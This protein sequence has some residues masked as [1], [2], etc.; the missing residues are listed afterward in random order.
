M[1]ERESTPIPA[2]VLGI[3]TIRIER[4]LLKRSNLRDTLSSSTADDNDDLDDDDLGNAKEI[5]LFCSSNNAPRIF[6]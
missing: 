4:A 3:A 2:A 6:R 5:A 1:Q